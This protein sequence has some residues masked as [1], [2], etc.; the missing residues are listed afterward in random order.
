MT[1]YL[2]AGRF[3]TLAGAEYTVTA[4]RIVDATYM[5][6]MVPSMR[7]PPYRVAPGID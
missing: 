5:R 4:R 7:P 1:E 3:T 6:V 2:G